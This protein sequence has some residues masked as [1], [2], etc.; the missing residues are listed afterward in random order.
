MLVELAEGRKKEPLAPD[1]WVSIVDAMAAWMNTIDEQDSSAL[2]PKYCEDKP[3]PSTFPDLYVLDPD[4][5][6]HLRGKISQI[7]P[8]RKAKVR[9]VARNAAAY[10]AGACEAG[11]VRSATR[12]ARVGGPL[13]ELPAYKWGLDDPFPRIW[14]CQMDPKYPFALNVGHWIFLHQG[15]LGAEIDRW[16][17]QWGLETMW[18]LPEPE[19]TKEESETS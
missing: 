2:P 16:R 17:K 11:R 6:L 19:E 7:S 8:E 14:A 18:T 15:D 3:I 4:P 5:P 10:I 9:R 12:H 13:C 1:G